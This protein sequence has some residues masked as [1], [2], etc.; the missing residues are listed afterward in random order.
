[1]PLIRGANSGV[2]ALVDGR[3][4]IHNPTV[5]RNGVPPEAA[6]RVWRFGVPPAAAPLT[7]YTRHG[8][9]PLAI[10]CLAATLVLALLAWREE[11]KVNSK[12]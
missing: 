1:L 8:D 6:V 4:R 9:W 2:T 7:P 11:R 10:P 12:Q 3:G 5:N